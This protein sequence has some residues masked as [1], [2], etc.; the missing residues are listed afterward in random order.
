[1]ARVCTLQSAACDSSGKG[2]F[3]PSPAFDSPGSALLKVS[4]ASVVHCNQACNLNENAID[5][6]GSPMN[7]LALFESMHCADSAN[8]FA[9]QGVKMQLVTNAGLWGFVNVCMVLFFAI[10][11][12]NPYASLRV[13][14]VEFCCSAAV[15]AM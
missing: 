3:S 4:G 1:M 10:L 2:E 5:G 11:S 13:M 9:H 14:L 7:S 15:Q 6:K 12:Y 8:H